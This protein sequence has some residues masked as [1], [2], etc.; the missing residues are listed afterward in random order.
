MGITSWPTLSI[1]AGPQTM[2]VS[3]SSQISALSQILA[4]TAVSIE[5]TAGGTTASEAHSTARRTEQVGAV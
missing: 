5:I 3:T 2:V 1:Q 4:N